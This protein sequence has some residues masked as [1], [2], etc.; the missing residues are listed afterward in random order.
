LTWDTLPFQVIMN[1]NNASFERIA[2]DALIE[3]PA[4]VIKPRAAASGGDHA[5]ET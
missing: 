3:A 2:S 5:A 1:Q 4:T